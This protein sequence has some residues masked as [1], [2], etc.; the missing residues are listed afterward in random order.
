VSDRREAAWE[1]F[2]ARFGCKC[3]TLDKV[4]LATETFDFVWLAGVEAYRS[5]VAEEAGKVVLD[6]DTVRHLLQVEV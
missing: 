5:A 2:K 4:G 3:D 6:R 1:A